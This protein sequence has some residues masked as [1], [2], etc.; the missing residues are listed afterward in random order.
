MNH[1]NLWYKYCLC[2]L[3]FAHFHFPLLNNAMGT[4]ILFTFIHLKNIYSFNKWKWK[5]TLGLVHAQ[6][7]LYLPVFTPEFLLV[8]E[9][10]SVLMQGSISFVRGKNILQGDG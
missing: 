7:C 8:Q 9:K 2:I 1:F 5:L 6:A 3:L 10:A 4:N